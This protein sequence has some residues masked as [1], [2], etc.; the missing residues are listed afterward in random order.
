MLRAIFGTCSYA[1]QTAYDNRMEQHETLAPIR[2]REGMAPLAPAP[3]P[4]HFDIP[5]LSGS[6]SSEQYSSGWTYQTGYSGGGAGT[7]GAAHDDDDGI[8][9][10]NIASDGE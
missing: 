5:N 9:W 10:E 8:D 7:S 2:A 4:P 6:S 1:A 3:P